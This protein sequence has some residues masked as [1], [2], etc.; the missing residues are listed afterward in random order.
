MYQSYPA[1]SVDAVKVCDVKTL[2]QR[3]QLAVREPLL[4][5]LQGEGFFSSTENQV[6]CSPFCSDL[7]TLYQI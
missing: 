1:V 6:V 5:L 2:S 3:A 4:L 7:R